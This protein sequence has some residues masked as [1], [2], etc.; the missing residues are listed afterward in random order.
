MVSIFGPHF[1]ERPGIAGTMFS[2]LASA[3]IN[4]LAISTSISSLCCII[5]ET[6]MEPAVEV[7]REAFELP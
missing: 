7:L 3:S 2:A 6:D 4:I 1:A 5:E